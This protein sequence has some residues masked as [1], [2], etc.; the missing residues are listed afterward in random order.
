[1][2]RLTDRP[3]MTLDVYRGRKT[4]Q[5]QQ[6]LPPP[7]LQEKK[8]NVTLFGMPR[9]DRSTWAQRI[10]FLDLYGDDYCFATPAL[11]RCD[12]RLQFSVR[13]EFRSPMS[14]PLHRLQG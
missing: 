4:T 2:V 3:D 5:Q 6:Q 9:R 12:I 11:A 8:V 7:P 13:P 1:M 14:V 10:Y